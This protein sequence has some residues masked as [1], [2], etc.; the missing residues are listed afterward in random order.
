MVERS[1]EGWSEPQVLPSP[2]NSDSRDGSYTATADG[3]VYISS[4]RPDGFGG[5]DIWHIQPKP[6]QVLHAENL[7]PI[8]NSTAFDVS[9]LIAPDGSYLIFGSERNGRRGEAHL[10]ICFKKGNDEWT[11]PINMNSCGAKVNNETAHH[12]GPSLSP[13]GKFLFFRRHE[14]MMDMDVY[15]VNANIIDDLKKEVFN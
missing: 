5:Y 3:V 6:N 11:T 7:G 14:S 9:P 4:K 8:M 1:I 10:Y 2:I 15:W 13:D 12:S